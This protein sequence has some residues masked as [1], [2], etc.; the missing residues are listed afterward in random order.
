MLLNPGNGFINNFN[1]IKMNNLPYDKEYI[2]DNKEVDISLPGI[3]LSDVE[4][5][6]YFF[7]KYKVSVESGKPNQRM[8]NLLK[9]YIDIIQ[10]N[11]SQK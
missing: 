5:L 7:H 10:V 6:N 4:N 2:F 1:N 9:R 3:E 8:A 11:H